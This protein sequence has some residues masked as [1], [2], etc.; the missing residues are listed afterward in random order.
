METLPPVTLGAIIFVTFGIALAVHGPLEKRVVLSAYETYQPNRQFFLDFGI[1]LGAGLLA[2]TYNRLTYHIQLKFGLAFFI[3]YVSVGFFIALDMALAR[4]RTVIAE[5]LKR[6]T[7]LPPPKQ[8]YSMTRRFF[9]VTMGT[10]L[11]L[12][13]VISL[14]ISRDMVWLTRA[15]EDGVS[16]G[17]SLSVVLYELIFIMGVLLAMVVNIVLSYSKNLKLLFTT[18]TGVLE[19]VSRGDLSNLVPVATHDEFGTIAGHTNSMIQGLR[20]R[21]QL[22]SA[23]SVAEEVQQNLLPKAPP[24]VEGLD[25]AGTSLYCEQVGG[26]Y[27]DYLDLPGDRL[28]IVVTDASGHGVGSALHMTTARAFLRF[29][30]RHYQ[31]PARLL[32]DVNRFLAHDASETGRF[33]TLFFLEINPAEKLLRWVRAGHDPAILYDSNQNAF[34]PLSGDGVALGVMPDITFEDTIRQGWNPGDVILVSTDGIPE[35]RDEM[36]KMYGSERLRKVIQNHALKSA[37]TILEA[38]IDSLTQFRG[39]SPQ[40]DDITLVVVKLL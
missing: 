11:L 9:L 40:E 18:E 15:H 16:A 1:C 21:F 33:T 23:L 20:H 3:G 39:E 30:T 13:L 25:I 29:G 22:M 35:T 2:W 27:Y 34:E 17:Q 14:V 6:D 38:I 12:L 7:V 24:A 31:G 10:T 5:A 4:E 36:G 19:Q 32:E 28:G 8:L 26:D 37:G